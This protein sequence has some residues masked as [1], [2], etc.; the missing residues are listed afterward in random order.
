MYR[1][2]TIG[3]VVP[4]YNEAGLVGEVLDGIP[5]YV[6]RVYA[7]D[8]AS[9]DETWA[10]IRAHADGEP[11][12]GRAVADASAGSAVASDG[13]SGETPEATGEGGEV[14]PTADG[15]F[16]ARVVPIRHEEN[17][18]AGGAIKTGYLAARADR[19]DVTVTVDADGQ[20]D[21][22]LMPRFLDPIVEGRADYAKGNRFLADTEEMPQFRLVGNRMLSLLTKIASGYWGVADPQNGYTAISLRALDGMDLEGMYEYY[23]Y[24]NDVLVKL[25]RADMRVADVA[26]P[27]KYDEE[28][29][30]IQYGE[31]VR[32]VSTMLLANFLGRL[33]RK[34]LLGD[35]AARPALA[36]Y[37]GAAAVALGLARLL[38]ALRPSDDGLR[39]ALGRVVLG[40]AL[41]LVAMALDRAE[42]RE[43]TIREYGD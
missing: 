14:A 5:S 19:V 22:D 18:G 30:H 3:V 34:H 17:R 23:G 9:T 24:C 42:H 6:D 7:V 35:G 36:Y 11:R 39:G 8:D 29:S 28:E 25:N 26:Q 13:T 43:L 15:G 37:A 16:D 33:N 2:H 32:R 21:T 27:A 31:Y 4:A 10:E 41:L 20:M 38:A 40:V 12:T 1:E